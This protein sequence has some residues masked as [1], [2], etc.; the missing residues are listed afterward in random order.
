MK[1]TDYGVAQAIDDM[2]DRELDEYLSDKD[3]GDNDDD[4]RYHEKKD[5]EA[6]EVG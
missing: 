4:R 2:K 1:C 6:T 5:D 3:D